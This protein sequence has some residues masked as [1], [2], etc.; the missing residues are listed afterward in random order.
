MDAQQNTASSLQQWAHRLA[1]R[2]WAYPLILLVGML[3]FLPNLG[4]HGLWDIDEAHNAEC[5]REMLEAKAWVVPT[6]NYQLRTDKP[7]LLYWLSLIH[8]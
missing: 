7:V 5:A 4:K 3:T 6:F 8:I 2:Q 1:E